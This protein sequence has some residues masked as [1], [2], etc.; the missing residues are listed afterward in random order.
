MA[1]LTNQHALPAAIVEAIRRDDYTRGES[2]I[3]VS[4]LVAPPRLVAL[5]ERHRHEI[6]E[7]ASDML[8]RL[9]G[10]AMHRVL[11]FAAADA[12]TEERLFLEVCEHHTFP[13]IA[14]VDMANPDRVPCCPHSWLV[15]GQFDNLTLQETTAGG[16]HLTDW[17]FGS[18]WGYKNGVKAEYE[19][20]LNLYALLL[21][22]HGFEVGVLTLGAIYRDWSKMAAQ[23]DSEYPQVGAQEFPV[24]L[25]SADEAEAYLLDRVQAHQAARRVLPECTADERWERPTKWAVM[26]D[27]RQSALRLLDTP[28][29]ADAWAVTSGIADAIEEPN[30][31]QALAMLH[32]GYRIEERPGAAIRC[33][34]YCEVGMNGFC[35][36]W[37]AIREAQA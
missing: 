8:Y 10:K 20:Q 17:K 12:I 5:A 19:A 15:S 36:Q 37:N 34:N 24:R 9:M 18:L 6:V 35:E 30:T 22:K 4:Q 32:K 26:K 2:D 31:G 21:R 25:W 27:G 11:E 13:V 14:P 16:W 7:D 1:T 3:S 33:G 23:R 29:D 28:H